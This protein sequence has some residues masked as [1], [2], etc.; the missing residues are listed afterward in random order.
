MTD[1]PFSDLNFNPPPRLRLSPRSLWM[2]AIAIGYWLLRWMLPTG[3]FSW[4]L[5][6]LLVILAWV[7]SFGWRSAIREIAAWIHMLERF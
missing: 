5:F 6:F 4:L 2:L 7:A 1:N 3:G